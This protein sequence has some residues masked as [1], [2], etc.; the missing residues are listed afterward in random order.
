MTCIDIMYQ[1]YAQY[2]P[3]QRPTIQPSLADTKKYGDPMTTDYSESNQSKDRKYCGDT[4]FLSAN[5]MV[6][7]YYKGDIS[8]VVDEHFTRALSQTGSYAPD[9]GKGYCKDGPPMSQRNFPPSF[10][11]QPATQA[12]GS[13]GH[14]PD[15][16]YTDPYHAGT[17]HTSLHQGD[18]WHYTLSAP[19]TSAYRPELTYP[20]ANRFSPQYGSF[21][22]QPSVRTTRLNPVAGSCTALDKSTDTWGAARY[23]DTLT[24]NL[25]H[26]ETNYGAAYSPMGTMSD[27]TSGNYMFELY[28]M[29]APRSCR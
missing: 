29:H 10:W 18:P 7:T 5:C 15:L 22:L 19:P 11:N 12:L 27:A 14:P 1:P 25:G 23:T 28:K 24:H 20:S 4:H 16:S 21:L 13:A 9:P 3:Y 8:S 6:V 2:F 26:M 17:L